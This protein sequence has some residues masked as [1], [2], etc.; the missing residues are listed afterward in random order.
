M[1]K[2]I[3]A[4]VIKSLTEGVEYKID[5]ITVSEGIDEMN[6]FID[7][8]RDDTFRIE[9]KFYFTVDPNIEYWTSS[10]DK[11]KALNESIE[12]SYQTTLLVLCNKGL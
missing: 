11:I 8:T 7:D 5:N 1:A 2:V 12:I 3:I 9:Y 10:E 6:T 4:A